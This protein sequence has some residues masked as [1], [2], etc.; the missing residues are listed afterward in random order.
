MRTYPRPLTRI[1]QIE[2]S[3]QCNLRCKYC[4]HPKLERSKADMSLSTFIAALD[5]VKYYRRSGENQ[6]ELSLTGMGEAL[7]HPLVEDMCEQARVA[8]GT[9]GKLLIATNGILINEDNVKWLKEHNVLLYISTHRPE[10]AGLAYNLA[11][12]AGVQTYLNTAFVNS[13]I[14]W[15]GQVDWQANMPT[16]HVCQYLYAGWGTVLQNGDIVNC[17]MDAHG[18]HV[19]GNVHTDPDDLEIEPIPLC[20]KCQLNVA[21]LDTEL[22]IREV[23]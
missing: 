5:W 4:P 20:D 18:K 16:N 15:A 8:L 13:S 19:I 10:R 21:P 17:C 2:I 23:G 9:E 22:R 3:S 6:T 7:M 12:E 11:K 1:H 14:D